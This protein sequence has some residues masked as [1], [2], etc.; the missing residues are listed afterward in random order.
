MNEE[1]LL[2]LMEQFCANSNITKI[3]EKAHEL[4]LEF[5]LYR[6]SQLIKDFVICEIL[7]LI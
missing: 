6:H 2:S 5:E 7:K 1:Q 3:E 4:T